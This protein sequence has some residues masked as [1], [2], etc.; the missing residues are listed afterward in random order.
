MELREKIEN[1]TPFNE[2]EEK[3][4]EYF[5]SFIDTFDDV[6]TRINKFG[7]FSSSAWVLN[8]KRTKILVVHHNIYN[9]Y[10]YPGGHADG[11]SDL[12]SVAIREV[13]EELG[14]DSKPITD[15]IFA[16]Q[17]CPTKG[18]VKRGEYVSAHT[19]FDVIY[20]LEAAEN[21]LLVKKEDENSS[22]KW[23]NIEDSFNEEIVDFIRPVNEKIYTKVKML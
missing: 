17:A 6:L 3:D 14:V 18:H 23:I 22:V 11:E 19:H 1:Y 16:I 15:E 10:I 5:L 8:E 21:Q 13:K 7:H 2:Q 12:L 20:L 9:A 4:K